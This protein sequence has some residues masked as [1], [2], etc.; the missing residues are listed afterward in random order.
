L[1]YC[2]VGDTGESSAGDGLPGYSNCGDCRAELLLYLFELLGPWLE[3]IRLVINLGG[4]VLVT[5]P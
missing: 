2:R 4:Q 5:N 3:Y 1:A